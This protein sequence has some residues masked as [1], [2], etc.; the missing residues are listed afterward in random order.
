MMKILTATFLNVGSK[1]FT[2]SYNGKKL[3]VFGNKNNY[4]II[5]EETLFICYNTWAEF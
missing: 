3:L 2:I 5:S 4:E 1:D